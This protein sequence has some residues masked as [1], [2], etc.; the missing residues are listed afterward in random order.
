M[1]R[2]SGARRRREKQIFVARSRGFVSAPSSS[3]FSLLSFSSFLSSAAAGPAAALS[4]APGA[5]S[6]F[7]V[8]GGQQL[9]EGL[10]GSAQQCL[11]ACF[12]VAGCNAASFCANLAG[13]E[14]GA[15]PANTCA[16]FKVDDALNPPGD[17]SAD[18]QSGTITAAQPQQQQ[19]QQVAQDAPVQQQQQPQQQQQQ[20]QQQ[21]SK[22]TVVVLAGG[23]KSPPPPPPSPGTKP[24]LT[25]TQSACTPVHLQQAGN[26]TAGWG[27]G[28]MGPPGPHLGGRR[29]MSAAASK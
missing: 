26:P 9:G 18:W 12:G 3:L 19:Q 24:C 10:Q 14:G 21:P 27:T 7:R 1:R 28:Q 13:C 17:A 2:E 11:D 23:G 6:S 22:T 8:T 15:K 5:L 16:W 4:I 20:Q 29:M 25:A